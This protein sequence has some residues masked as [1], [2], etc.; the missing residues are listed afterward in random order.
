MELVNG[1]AK[2]SA[3]VTGQPAL[4]VDY[5]PPVGD[6]EGYTSLELLLISMGTCLGTAVKSLVEHRLKKKVD[7]LSVGA[8]GERREKHPTSFSRVT[9]WLD[10]ACQGLSGEELVGVIHN[11]EANICPVLD[12]VKGNTE[13]VV[14]PHLFGLAVGASESRDGEPIE[15]ASA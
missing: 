6:G 11:A 7:S 8:M 4:S 12:M 10:I 9:L 1:R 3:S 14:K 2:F 13:I 15:E 5:I